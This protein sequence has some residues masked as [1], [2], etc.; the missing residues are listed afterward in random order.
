MKNMPS[1]FHNK[2]SGNPFP[3]I[4]VGIF[5]LAFAVLWLSALK[6]S[7]QTIRYTTETFDPHSIGNVVAP[8]DAVDLIPVSGGPTGKIWFWQGE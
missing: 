7:G 8:P 3:L 1:A 5:C 4:R 2:K 6:G